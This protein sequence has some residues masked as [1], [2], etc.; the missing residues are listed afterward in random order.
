MAPPKN[1]SLPRGTVLGASAQSVVK[2]KIR[3]VPLPRA[4]LDFIQDN[5]LVLRKIL[6][7]RKLKEEAASS[8]MRNGSSSQPLEGDEDDLVEGVSLHGDV[9]K[10]PTVKPEEFWT[11]LE[12]ACKRAGV[13]WQCL[14]D[15]IWAFGP[16]TAGGCV[17]V[18]ARKES[19]ANS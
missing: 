3:A 6:R 10:K 2:F 5:L 17:L 13:E 19:A 8:S 12:A 11:G 16:Q 7:E 1:P 4:I 14:A 9:F 18:D 15:K